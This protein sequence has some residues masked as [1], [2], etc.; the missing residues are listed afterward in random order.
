MRVLSLDIFYI[1]LNNDIVEELECLPG[2]ENTCVDA[3]CII[4]D[5]DDWDDSQN[6]FICFLINCGDHLPSLHSII[7]QIRAIL[8]SFQSYFTPSTPGVN[9]FAYDWL[10]FNKWIVP[11]FKCTCVRLN[12]F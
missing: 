2:N 9:A 11:L 12:I 8:C 6:I 5:F 1:C 4:F 7:L 10:T 3:L